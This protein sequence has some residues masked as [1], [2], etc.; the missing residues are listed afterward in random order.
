MMSKTEHSIPCETSGLMSKYGENKR[1]DTHIYYSLVTPLRL[2]AVSVQLPTEPTRTLNSSCH[3][4]HCLTQV[5]V[6]Q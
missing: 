1:V 4:Q 6:N 3:M 5:N 2:P